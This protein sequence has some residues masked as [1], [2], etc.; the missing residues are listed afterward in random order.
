MSALALQKDRTNGILLGLAIIAVGFLCAFLTAL[1]VVRTA[2]A[3]VGRHGFAPFAVYR[4]ILG[5]VML[6]LLLS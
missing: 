2:I 1:I 5:V 6:G 4:I 3:F